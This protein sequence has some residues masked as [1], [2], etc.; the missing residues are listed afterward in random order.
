MKIHEIKNNV[1]NFEKNMTVYFNKKTGKIIACH[2]GIADMTPYKKQDPELLEIWDYE[3]LPINN[4][5]IYNKDN[6]KIQNGEIRLIK[7][8]NQVK[9]RIAD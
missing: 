2:S 1:E 6:F 4:E 5:V 9:Y 3:I 8:L 7:T